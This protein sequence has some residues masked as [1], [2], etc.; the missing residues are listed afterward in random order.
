VLLRLP[1]LANRCHQLYS[2]LLFVV[3]TH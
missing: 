3:E 2:D 1:L